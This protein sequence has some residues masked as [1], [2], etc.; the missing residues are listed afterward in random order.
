MQPF[1]IVLYTTPLCE[2]IAWVTDCYGHNTHALCNMCSLSGKT[3]TLRPFV[4]MTVLHLFW[5][6]KS[7]RLKSASKFRSALENMK[8]A[9]LHTILQT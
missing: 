7:Y 8:Y 4:S 6:M 9:E 3:A 1:L 2:T 5:Q